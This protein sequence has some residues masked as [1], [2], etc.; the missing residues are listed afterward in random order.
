[1]LLAFERSAASERFVSLAI[2]LTGVRAFAVVFLFG[3]CR[4]IWLITFA[5]PRYRQLTYP[6]KTLRRVGGACA[7][8]PLLP[9]TGV[10]RIN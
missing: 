7:P 5:P 3:L 4:K 6:S 2:F 1:M 8:C 9:H 10:D